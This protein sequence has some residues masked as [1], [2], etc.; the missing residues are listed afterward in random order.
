MN[1]IGV[2]NHHGAVVAG[3]NFVKTHYIEYHG[4]FECRRGI[5]TF[6][7]V[8]YAMVTLPK[9]SLLGGRAASF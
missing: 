5:V 8:C 3:T 2:G 9:S 4:D 6:F 7:P 1:L